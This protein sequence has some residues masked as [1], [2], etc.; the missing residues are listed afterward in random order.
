MLKKSRG[1]ILQ[2][3]RYSDSK[4]IIKIFTQHQGLINFATNISRSKSAKIKL[5]HLQI[6]N[7]VEISYNEK[8]NKD[9]Q[10]LNE[11][12]IYF[13]YLT[14]HSNISKSS[15]AVFINEV[16]QHTLKVS[17][18]NNDLFDFLSI[19]LQ[20]LDRTDSSV[21]DFHLHFLLEFTRFLGFFPHEE[22][23]SFQYFD[24]RDGIYTQS[25]P[26]HPDYLKG[27]ELTLFTS[28][29]IDS[30]NKVEFLANRFQR[31][32]LLEIL[33]HYYKVHIPS[34]PTLK[35]IEVLREVFQ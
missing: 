6:L 32:R 23:N 30:K 11:L 3:L 27:D 5:S 18:S 2:T 28:F 20:W 35:S 15:I 29:I 31:N 14:L 7:Q 8:P 16:L 12:N 22:N 33:I 17:E 24:L 9:I 21:P 13:P 19:N 25:A 1:I 34:F 4:C 26:L 10:F